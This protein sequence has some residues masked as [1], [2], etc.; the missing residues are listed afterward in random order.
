MARPAS[1]IALR[2]QHAARDR[3]LLE[4][5]DGASL[6]QIAKDAGTNIGMV[7]YYFKTKDDLFL[8]VVEEVYAEML[9]D[10]VKALANDVPPEQRIERVYQRIARM[11]ET[12]FKVLR[13]I[14]REA[15]ISSARLQKVAQRFQQGHL[16]LIGQLLGE[17]IA[18]GRFRNDVHPLA[19]GAAM[20][21]LGIM[22]QIAVRL[23]AR[24]ELPIAPHLPTPE[25]AAAA[26]C[27]ILLSGMGGPALPAR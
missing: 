12:E 21:T 23:L 10:L 2:L 9:K 7:Y 14:L 17:G 15:I 22:P 6:R 4:G 18:T 19:L 8:A 24:S 1:D 27:Q 20:F 26:L 11:D 5:V 25:Q 13:L 16:P 3:F